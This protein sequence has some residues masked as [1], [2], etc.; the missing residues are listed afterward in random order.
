MDAEPCPIPESFTRL[1]VPLP[2]RLA[3]LLGE[4]RSRYFCLYTAGNGYWST[5]W[6]SGSFVPVAIFKPLLKHPTLALAM[7]DF[8]VCAE[9]CLPPHALVADRRTEQWYVGEFAQAQQFL[10]TQ[11]APPTSPPPLP[12]IATR[13][14]FLIGEAVDQW[15]DQFVTTELLETYLEVGWRSDHPLCRNVCACVEKWRRRKRK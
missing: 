12:P 7:T 3:A 10:Q 14:E 9:D 15:L 4:N 1:P 13:E 8:V 11:N 5:G 2:P 6:E